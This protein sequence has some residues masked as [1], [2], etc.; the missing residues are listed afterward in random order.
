MP[1][2]RFSVGYVPGESTI[3]VFGGN[4]N[5]RGPIWMPV[6]F[7]L[8]E[9]LRRFHSYYGDDFQVECPVG[10]GKLMNLTEVADEI[11]RRLCRHLPARRGRAAPGLRRPIRRQDRPDF[12]D[13]L[14]FYEYFHGDTG[15][16]LGA[17][18]QTGWTGLIAL[19][20]QAAA[21]DRSDPMPHSRRS[22]CSPGGGV[23]GTARD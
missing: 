7:L 8:I 15:R 16:G 3:G 13:D 1:A 22:R 10:S 4:S 14:L 12:R 2:T 11:T 6:N 18:H 23:A 20:L 17:A 9:S 19:L 21:R 5:W